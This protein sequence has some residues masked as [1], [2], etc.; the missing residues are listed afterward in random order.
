MSNKQFGFKKAQIERYVKAEYEK[1]FR[2]HARISVRKR[3]KFMDDMAR[4]VSKKFGKDVLCLIDF[5][6]GSFFSLISPSHT[7]STNLGR[8]FDSFAHTQISYTSH[9]LERFSE[10]ADSNENCIIKMDCYMKEALLTY[11][12]NVG[13]LTC[14]AGVFAYEF[15]DERMIIKTYINFDLLS[16]EQINKFYGSGTATV[17]AK[18]YITDDH[19]QSDFKLIDENEGSPDQPLT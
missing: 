9:C 6:R 16:E 14:P 2:K 11:G 8:L 19:S 1:K 10:R 13:H 15:M 4:K 5:A 3:Q 12:E 18:E 17:I 7:E